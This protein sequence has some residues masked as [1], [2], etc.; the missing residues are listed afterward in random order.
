M[1]VIY[2]V[3]AR[4]AGGG[5]G[6]PAYHAA[7][8]IWRAGA[9]ARLLV[10]SYRPT[11]IPV[12]VIRSMGWAGRALKRVA[13]WD[14]SGH[15]YALGDALFDRWASRRIIPCDIFHGWSTMCR[16]SLVQAKALGAM[17]VIERASSHPLGQEGILRQLEERYDV[18]QRPSPWHVRWALEEFTLADYVAVPSEFVWQS[19]VQRGFPA[20][21]LLFLPYGV[22]TERFRP[23]DPG[24]A[25]PHPF[26][27]LFVGQVTARKGV[28]EL[29][30]AWRRLNWRDAELWIAG[31]PDAS[32]RCR[33][34]SYAGLAG[35]RCLG[36]IS[37]P[38]ALYQG[39]DVFVFPSHEEGSALVTYEAMACGLPMITTFQAG[40]V[41]RRGEEALIIPAGD[42]PALMEALGRLREDAE[43]RRRLGE[44]A[45]RRAEAFSWE[46]YG[47]RLVEA[48]T[49]ILGLAV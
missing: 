31:R 44:A 4:L 21:R 46:A 27:A 2:A 29:L 17:T 41:A 38:V 9:L 18:H 49:R 40:S 14:S 45:R 48:Y 34:A 12:N 15:L 42:V 28:L 37:D 10:S 23:A 22:D 43:L 6:T 13:L 30:E 7:A 1:R 32:I 47:R 20:E 36:Y 5:I 25:H 35:V 24:S 39:A 26:R 19:F 33:L 3:G 11:S 8:G 16:H